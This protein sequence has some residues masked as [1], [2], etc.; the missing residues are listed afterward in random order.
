[1]RWAN[2]LQHYKLDIQHKKGK[3][4]VAAD[5]LSQAYQWWHL[6][7]ANGAKC[8]IQFILSVSCPLTCGSWWAGPYLSRPA[9]SLCLSVCLSLSSLRSRQLQ[10]H[11][12]GVELFISLIFLHSL[13]FNKFCSLNCHACPW[14]CHFVRY[15]PAVTALCLMICYSNIYQIF[16]CNTKTSRTHLIVGGSMWQLGKSCLKNSSEFWQNSWL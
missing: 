15:E 11:W 13:I 1:M 6:S 7:G 2:I 9:V 14:V 10:Q 5:V 8:C 16:I 3:H 12:P 4:N